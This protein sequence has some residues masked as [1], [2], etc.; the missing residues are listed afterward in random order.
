[1]NCSGPMPRS[2]VTFSVT[3][4]GFVA[5]GALA[6]SRHRLAVG[7]SSRVPSPRFFGRCQ[8][9][10]RSARYTASPSR[11]RK[12]TFGAAPSGARSARSRPVPRVPGTSP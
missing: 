12:T 4:V 5:S 11:K 10:V 8:A 9:A 1:M 7:A 6:P 3:T 2:S